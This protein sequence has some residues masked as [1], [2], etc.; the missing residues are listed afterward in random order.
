MAFFGGGRGA[1]KA[2][3]AALGKAAIGARP[4]TCMGAPMMNISRRLFAA[5]AAAL[6]ATAGA[7]SAAPARRRPQLPDAVT[8]M[9]RATR[10]MTD[11]VGVRG[12][13]VWTY[14]PDFSRR[15]GELEARPTMIWVQPPGTPSMGH[16]FLDAFHATGEEEYYRAATAAADALIAGQLP[17]GGWNY[18]IDFAG[19]ASLANWYE[20]I[21]QNAWRLEEFQRHDGNATFDDATTS[22]AATLLLRMV[23]EKNGADAAK[24]RPALDRAIAFVMQAQYESGAWPQRY[25]LAEPADYTTFATFNDDVASENIK[26]LVQCYR[27]TGD[28]ALIEAIKKAM[29]AYLV[30]QQP[31][32]QA[33]WAAYYTVADMK[34]AAGRSYEPLALSTAVTA[35]AVSNC[36]TFFEITGERKYI[37]R[38]PE[39]LA[40]LDSVALPA[41]DVKDG[42][43]HPTWVE[44]GKNKPLYVHRFGSNVVN[45]QY[46][47]NNEP[48]GVIGHYP[49]TRAIDTAGLRARYEALKDKTP[50]EVTKGHPLVKG[51]PLPR[52]YTLTGI[53]LKGL[54]ANRGW[55]PANAPTEAKVREI[56]QGLNS[57]GF[58]ATPLTETSRPYTGP[59]AATATSGDFSQTRA[60]DATDTSPFDTN[61]PMLGISVATYIRNMAVLV[62]YVDNGEGGE[63][64]VQRRWF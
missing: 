19:E 12:G 57:D 43:T 61:A 24:Y 53:E 17:S 4:G 5:S 54:D 25:P 35:A 50:S 13:Y 38:V 47:A 6:A 49:Q 28:E 48:E 36:M 14:L 33:G 32:P 34:P 22:E 45:G 55:N 60:G 62:Q 16:A 8:A 64:P 21:G 40:W 30:A 7:A 9:R 42:L 10:F 41:E 11:R 3:P 51:A 18:M 58:W 59:G 39:A 2:A 63:D 20:T 26:F 52:F 31:A 46:F 29:D 15:W 56:V 23:T 37:E 27:V 44:I 1:G